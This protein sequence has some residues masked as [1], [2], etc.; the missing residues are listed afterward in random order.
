MSR[1]TLALL[2]MAALTADANACG[3][4]DG[5]RQRVQA[6]RDARAAKAPACQAAPAARPAYLPATLPGSAPLVLAGPVVIAAQQCAGGTCP[7]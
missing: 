7:K 3:L 4:L 5:C 1:L 6:R 2:L